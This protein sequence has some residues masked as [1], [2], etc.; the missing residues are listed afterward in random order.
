[1]PHKSGKG[2]AYPA[3]KG[4]PKKKRNPTKKKASS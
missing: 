4:H 2:K 3:R 1:M